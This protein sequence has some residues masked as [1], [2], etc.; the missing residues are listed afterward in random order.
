[1]HDIGIRIAVVVDALLISD[2]AT[3]A[4]AAADDDEL[5]SVHLHQNSTR[6]SLS[7]VTAAALTH[8]RV[9]YNVQ[10]FDIRRVVWRCS[11]IVNTDTVSA[12]RYRSDYVKSQPPCGGILATVW[13]ESVQDGDGDNDDIIITFN[14]DKTNRAT[15]Q[16]YTILCNSLPRRAAMTWHTHAVTQDSSKQTGLAQRG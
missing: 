13:L 5:L 6:H 14:A 12:T 11:D 15:L 8:R 16:H 1:M 7:P 2:T 4:A 10:L 3:A 9:Q